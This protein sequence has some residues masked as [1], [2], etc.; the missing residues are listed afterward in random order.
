[1]SD[2]STQGDDILHKALH[3]L[4]DLPLCDRCLGRL[5]ARLG[6]GWDNKSRG[7]S[8]K[9]LVVMSLHRKIIAG[10]EEAKRFFIS[11]APNIGLQ[12]SGLYTKITG[13]KLE[14]KSCV[15]CKGL[16]DRYIKEIPERALP[17]LRLYNIRKFVV[18]VSVPEEL[19]RFEEEIKM[20][21]NLEYSESIKAELRREI[22]KAIQALDPSIRADFGEPEATLMVWF[23]RGELDLKVNSLLLSGVYW[24]RGRMISQ[25]Y[26]PTPSGPKYYSIEEALWPIL[27]LTGGE[28]LIIHAAGREDVDA[29]MLGTGRPLIIEVKSPRNRHVDLRRMEYAVVDASKG[30]VAVRLHAT[31][32]RRDIALYKE[33]VARL[34]K[35]YKALIV[36]G[37]PLSSN[38][39]E[40][41]ER[42]FSGSIIMQRTPHRVLHRRPDILRRRKVYDVKC[43]LLNDSLLECLIRAEGGLYIKELISGDNGRTKPSFSEVLGKKLKCVELDVLAVEGLPIPREGG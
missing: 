4:A 13:S 26:W 11:I 39:L 40:I 3:V 18:G 24:K 31:A 19:L 10:N 1:M 28:R 33:E 20:R 42:E 15:I 34:V 16:L 12:A 5:F 22:G 9:R 21:Y 2:A 25:A 14:P 32:R 30:V 43:I 23:P 35:T 17:L 38:D 37:A 41:L 29:R 36:S 8:L 6:Y 7:D 27:R